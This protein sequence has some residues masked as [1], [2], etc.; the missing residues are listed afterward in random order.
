MSRKT[1]VNEGV[2]LVA[3]FLLA[4]AADAFA[5]AT[6]KT[7][8]WIGASGD[9]SD[10]ANWSRGH[11]PESDE[12]VWF[13]H[14]G[15]SIEVTVDGNCTIGTFYVNEAE[16][17]APLTLKGSGTITLS[18][19]SPSPYIRKNHPFT[20]DGVTLD[21][22][23]A[24][25][26]WYSS[27]TLKNGGAFKT[28]KQAWLWRS[29]VCLTIDGGAYKGGG[30]YANAAS[31]VDLKSG[32]LICDNLFDSSHDVGVSLSVSGGTLTVNGTPTLND[33]TVLNLTGGELVFGKMLS[34]R[35]F[36]TETRGTIVRV[37]GMAKDGC[38]INLLASP[39][40]TVTFGA[41]VYASGFLYVTNAPNITIRA[42]A[43]A[44]LGFKG[45]KQA[46]AGGNSTL[47]V[48]TVVLGENQAFD[49][50]KEGESG[51]AGRV[52]DIQGPVTFRPTADMPLEGQKSVYPYVSGEAVIDSTDYNDP[53]AGRAMAFH[54][55]GAREHAM[56]K[57]RGLG[58][59]ALMHTHSATAFS[60]VEVESGSTLE[61]YALS[62]GAD[63]GPLNTELF[64]LGP[65]ATLK[66]PAGKNFVQAAKWQI[67]P[68]AKI[69]I[70]V[71]EGVAV[72]AMRV[73]N[74]L[75][76][77]L[78]S[79]GQVQLTGAG[80]AGWMSGFASGAL[81]LTKPTGAID[82][83]YEWEWTGLGADN[84]FATADNWVA[85]TTPVTDVIAYF[86]AGSEQRSEMTLGKAFTVSGL[87][88]RDTAST[89]YV[90]S[91][92]ATFTVKL[93]NAG[94]IAKSSVVSHS[95]LPMNLNMNLRSG[96]NMALTAIDGALIFGSQRATAF[97]YDKAPAGVLE[98]AGDVR[99]AGA[100]MSYPQLGF[101]SV[102][103]AGRDF[104][105]ITGSHLTILADATLTL[106]NQ[107][108]SLDLDDY[109]DMAF[110]VNKGGVLT[111]RGGETAK[112]SWSR[113]PAKLVVDGELNVQVPFVGGVDQTYGGEGTVRL[114]SVQ[115]TTA[116]ATVT[117]SDAVVLEPAA[118]WPTATGAEDGP[119]TLAA[120]GRPTIRL[121]SD[122]T[123]GTTTA[124]GT[125]STA[126]DRAFGVARGAVLTID[127]GGCVAT[128]ADPVTGEG[129][130]AV[131]NGIVRLTVGSDVT[132][133]LLD[134]SGVL[135]VTEN[136]TVGGIVSSGGTMRLAEGVSVCCTMSASVD[137]LCVDFADAVLPN[138]WTTVVAAPRIV[139]EPQETLD[140][141]FRTIEKDGIK[142]LQ[143]RRKSGMVLLFR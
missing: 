13:N 56:L 49:F 7:N 37:T 113:K 97:Q 64:V 125:T 9:W 33:K 127:A 138:R 5:A 137:G 84:L 67:D 143:C 128:F 66:V 117:L 63:Y 108:N 107:T 11:V 65:N 15:K 88:F 86:G 1:N 93:R 29:T 25:S 3:V 85:K 111:F 72:G 6:T 57:I 98:L 92:T 30:L 47:D 77:S 18:G 34:E 136:L 62:G 23:D 70:D 126:A 101:A 120:A 41:S 129:A 112:Y 135:D 109:S 118:D 115:T 141:K 40:E 17:S 45:F 94:S 73:L 39:N 24:E 83:Q 91:G 95:A 139:G 99:L 75:S 80:A 44:V 4:F 90:L 130:L 116:A 105:K 122:W 31:S 142:L 71:P 8:E 81:V 10:K 46:Y 36:L 27:V 104:S 140:L 60:K 68:M 74:D 102:E 16:K 54:G 100:Q 89:P 79:A 22:G 87:A 124:S 50:F 51:S 131:S 132:A 48:R 61:L 82:G 19:Y 59:V 106:T 32:V 114:S 69:V 55:L 110:R 35:R 38:S 119:L 121:S 14:S 52:F 103:E 2:A 134:P 28:T 53:T 78:V 21:V 58:S 12:L 20:L 123:Y 26:L 96:G 133:V 76:G 43:D 42:P